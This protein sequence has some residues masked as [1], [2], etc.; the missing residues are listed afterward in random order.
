MVVDHDDVGPTACGEEYAFVVLPAQM[1]VERRDNK[2]LGP[3]ERATIAETV[4]TVLRKA[5]V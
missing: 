5:A 3:R 4:F 2:G 1:P